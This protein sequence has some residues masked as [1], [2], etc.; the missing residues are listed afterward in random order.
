MC[1]CVCGGG[2]G[3]GGGQIALYSS[4]F[5]LRTAIEVT[6]RKRKINSKLS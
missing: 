5:L 6:E 2:G 3:G 4:S 1:V